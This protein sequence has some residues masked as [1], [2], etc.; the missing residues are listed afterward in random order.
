MD[1][2]SD[3]AIK[4]LAEIYKQYLEREDTDYIEANKFSPDFAETC[5][6]FGKPKPN[7]VHR[8]LQAL[9]ANDYIRQDVLGGFYLTDTGIAYMDNR[10]K[11]KIKSVIEFITDLI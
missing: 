4:V 2:I 3:D 10:F 7:L 9:H 6:V 8:C 11:G 1:N 5:L